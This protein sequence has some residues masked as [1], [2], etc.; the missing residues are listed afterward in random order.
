MLNP[1]LSSK[2]H[3]KEVRLCSVW[4][5]LCNDCAAFIQHRAQINLVTKALL[6]GELTCVS[7]R[8]AKCKFLVLFHQFNS[9]I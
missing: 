1:P 2:V 3:I 8:P 6:F 7:Y 4:Q 5:S 9:D